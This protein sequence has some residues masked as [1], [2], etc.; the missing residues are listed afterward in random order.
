[1]YWNRSCG[2]G[3]GLPTHAYVE[4]EYEFYFKG[5]HR[6]TYLMSFFFAVLLPILVSILNVALC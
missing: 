2:F 3:V 6:D 4:R 1:M 5:I